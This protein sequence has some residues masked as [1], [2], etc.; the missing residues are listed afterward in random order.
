MEATP[1]TEDTPK[2]GD[3]IAKRHGSSNVEISGD[4]EKEREFTTT[5][6][7]QPDSDRQIKA[8]NVEQFSMER[9]DGEANTSLDSGGLVTVSKIEQFSI[10][11]TDDQS[12]AEVHGILALGQN[13]IVADSPNEKLK[14]FNLTGVYLS[15]VDSN[16][17]VYGITAVTESQFATCGT[18]TCMRVWNLCGDALKE[19]SSYELDYDSN[20][21][22]HFNDT[23]YC[24]LNSWEHAITVLNTK[25]E[26]ISQI[27]KKEAFGRK[28]GFGYGIYMDR[29]TNNIYV[30][31]WGEPNSVMCLSLKG[32]DLWFTPI[33]GELAVITE[34]DGVLCLSDFSTGG[35]VHMV[36]KAGQNMGKGLGK[37]SLNDRKFNY[38]FYAAHLKILYF[39]LYDSD[40][41]CYASTHFQQ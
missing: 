7:F 22:M 5:K 23:Y 1:Q 17:G 19:S 2:R 24:V 35:C 3:N 11:R 12:Q 15:S 18:D 30:V 36:S 6:T 32:E 31:C 38:I 10:K 9:A 41:I 40:V 27:V 28:I 20:C 4:I 21:G 25:G 13:I 16:H 8:N 29:T 39:N 26:H 33:E 14:L 37:Y 34:I